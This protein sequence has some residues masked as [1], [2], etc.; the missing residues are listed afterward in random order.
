ML[1]SFGH[2]KNPEPEWSGALVGHLLPLD[3]D[4]EIHVD[5][6]VGDKAV[7]EVAGK[8]PVRHARTRGESVWFIAAGGERAFGLFLREVREG[9]VFYCRK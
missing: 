3:A 7:L 9:L 6:I 5:V 8:A 4:G 1:R 2:R